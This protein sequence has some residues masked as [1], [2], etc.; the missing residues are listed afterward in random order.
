MFA[1]M[2][3]DRVWPSRFGG[4]CSA[5]LPLAP[6]KPAAAAR[7]TNASAGLTPT[8]LRVV[9]PINVNGLS[10][11]VAKGEAATIV[12][13]AVLGNMEL[14]STVIKCALE[15][16]A[17]APTLASV[18]Q[19][20]N[21]QVCFWKQQIVQ[22]IV[23]SPVA[24]LHGWGA[25]PRNLLVG[26]PQPT[27]SPVFDA[28]QALGEKFPDRITTREDVLTLLDLPGGGNGWLTGGLID[29]YMGSFLH[30]V[31]RA[32]P[33]TPWQQR[34]CDEQPDRVYLA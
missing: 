6:Q 13:D 22:C 18:A 11:K 24:L 21:G 3:L 4:L 17:Q 33:L 31:R 32:R 29:G 26:M 12:A 25:P 23:S 30:D 7:A 28:F 5:G 10:V 34:I 20:W 14:L 15:S 16:N 19:A 1:K 8:S 2:T 27:I 9:A